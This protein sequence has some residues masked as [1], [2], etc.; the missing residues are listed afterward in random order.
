MQVFRCV[1]CNEKFRRPP[2][3]GV[4]TKCRGKLIFT[5]SQGSIVKYL[6]GA[7]ALARTYKVSPYLL[8]SLE[9]TEKDIEGIFGREKEK[10]ENLGKWFG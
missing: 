7:L 3:A 5:I 6:A 1:G 8:E 2:L 4:C 9:I 10:Q